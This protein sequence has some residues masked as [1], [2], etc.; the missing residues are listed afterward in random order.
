MII[1]TTCRIPLLVINEFWLTRTFWR[2]MGA[3]IGNETMIDPDVLLFEADMVDIGNNCRIEEM[4]TLLC[5]KFTQGS[6]EMESISIPSNAVIR[7]HAVILPGCK[8]TGN[9][10]KVMPLTH[11]LSGE[12]LSDGVWHGSPAEKVDIENG[13]V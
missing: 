11:V 7:S 8:I 12:E 9:R 13:F 10:V 5:H 6:L 3:S 2:L 4:A 1:S